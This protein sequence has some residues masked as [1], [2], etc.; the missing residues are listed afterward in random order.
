MEEILGH[1]G[2]PAEHL[3]SP[4]E[5]SSH[6]ARGFPLDLAD[7]RAKGRGMVSVL[8][9]R[10]PFE[11]NRHEDGFNRYRGA[12]SDLMFVRE[13]CHVEI[14]RRLGQCDAIASGISQRDQKKSRY[15]WCPQ[16]D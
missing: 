15:W 10:P 4:F 11:R 2:I 13:H 16:F 5:G 3:P 9:S 6:Q 1:E 8:A 7:R 14:E 12:R